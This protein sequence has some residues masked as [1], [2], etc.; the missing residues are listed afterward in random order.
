MGL[1]HCN[2]TMVPSSVTVVDRSY[3]TMA[4]W[5]RDRFCARREPDEDGQ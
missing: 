4:W 2:S 5:G 3:I 1:V